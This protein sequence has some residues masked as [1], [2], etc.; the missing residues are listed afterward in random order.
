MKTHHKE[1]SALLFYILVFFSVLAISAF[2]L[3]IQYQASNQSAAE[4]FEPIQLP[5]EDGLF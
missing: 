4:F 1:R 2:S 5:I 3:L